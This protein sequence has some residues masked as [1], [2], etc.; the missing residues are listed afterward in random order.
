MGVVRF[1]NR[2]RYQSH[3]INGHIIIAFGLL[4]SRKPSRGLPQQQQ[5]LSGAIVYSKSED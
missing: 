2:S 4:K 5:I 1:F 3:N